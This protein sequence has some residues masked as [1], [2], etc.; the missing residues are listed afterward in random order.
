[1]L[2]VVFIVSKGKFACIYNP[3]QMLQLSIFF[4]LI[5]DNNVPI[6]A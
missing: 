6:V 4:L 5:K 2:I 1:M 3:S